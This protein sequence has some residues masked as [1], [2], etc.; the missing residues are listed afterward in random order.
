MN[1]TAKGIVESVKDTIVGLI[2]GSGDIFNTIIDT[3]SGMVSNLAK[4]TGK[5]GGALIGSLQEIIG[6]TIHG[7]VDAGKNLEEGVKA[8]VIGIL[9]GVKS[10]GEEAF[11]TIA[12]LAVLL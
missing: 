2:K 10:T 3:V 7:I 4:D 8:L 11:S 5:T 1:V 9:K 12:T 6:A